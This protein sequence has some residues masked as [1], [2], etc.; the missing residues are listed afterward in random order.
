MEL[1]E[2]TSL[3]LA[4]IFGSIGLGYFV[5]GKKISNIVFRYTG[6]ALMVYPYFV[7]NKWAVLATGIVLIFIPKF[8]DI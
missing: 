8:I 5:Y 3:I 6:I 1:P 7:E 2:S 4:L